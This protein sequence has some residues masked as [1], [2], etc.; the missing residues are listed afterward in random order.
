MMPFFEIGPIT[1]PGYG[2]MILL[3][4]ICGALLLLWRA[5][6]KG[7]SR[8]DAFF[9][10]LYGGIGLFIGAKLLFLIQ[11]MP[12]IIAQW[13][14]LISDL[15]QLGSLLSSGFVFYGGLFGG[16]GGV[17]I[18][19]RQYHLS[20]RELL[21]IL[22]PV[23]PFIHAFGRIGCFMAGCCYGIPYDGPFHV[24]FE[25][26]FIAP[27]NTPLF[28]VQLLESALLM[29]L[30]VFLLT[31]DAKAKKP[32]SLIGWYLLLY[33]IIRMGTELLR[34][35]LER[36]FFLIFSTSQWISIALIVAAIIILVKLKVPP[37]S[38]VASA[39]I[40]ADLPA[41][42]DVDATDATDTADA[43]DIADV[44]DT[45]DAADMLSTDADSPADTPADATDTAPADADSPADSDL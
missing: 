27:R 5:K 33:A 3:G 13:D 37:K 36:G 17:W 4:I 41:E 19:A 10:F 15:A 9:A 32:R 22:I 12:E 23:V 6:R 21:E 45:A 1:L 11:A 26:A 24:V 43:A 44:T 28:P 39:G 40:S 16:I 8:Q 2:S 30:T 31:Y 34:G 29:L 42:T 25:I 38:A 7:Y 35:D 18:Y 14:R 20:F